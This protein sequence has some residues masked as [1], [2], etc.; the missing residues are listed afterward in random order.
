M[1][2]N[3]LSRKKAS[4]KINNFSK[5]R[6]CIWKHVTAEHAAQP[7]ASVCWFKNVYPCSAFVKPLHQ[8]NIQ[9]HLQ[10]TN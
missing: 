3:I 2:H 10:S 5:I 9:Q 1:N 6:T 8:V 7:M 4:Q